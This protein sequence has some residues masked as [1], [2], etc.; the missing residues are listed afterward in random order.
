MSE[1]YPAYLRSQYA[2]SLIEL[3]IVLVVFGI[4][5]AF[6][7]NFMRLLQQ[8]EIST[9][10]NE[11]V[12]SLK[13]ART[14]A[15]TRKTRITLCQS[16][17][18]RE[19]ERGTD[20]G[21]GWILFTDGNNNRLIDADEEVIQTHPGLNERISLYWKGSLGTNY[22]L[23]FLQTGF[24]NKAGSF[25]VCGDN[26]IL[27]QARRVVLARTGRVRTAVANPA[28]VPAECG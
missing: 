27:Q 14:V 26:A 3:L 9:Q 28:D 7:S 5:A 11:V 24:S 6:G 16:S 22:Y 23:S 2:F 12:A 13:L 15:I 8:Q 4:A 21:K 17:H 1:S 20:W 25:W 18:G 10:T 19:C